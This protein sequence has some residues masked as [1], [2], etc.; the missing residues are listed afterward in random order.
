MCM[1]ME[2]KLLVVVVAYRNWKVVQFTNLFNVYSNMTFLFRW[3]A[4]APQGQCLQNLSIIY[5]AIN[6]NLEK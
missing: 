2:I 3:F 5:V 1:V 6:N 4:W